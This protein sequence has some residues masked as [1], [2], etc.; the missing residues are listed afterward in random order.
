[1]QMHQML[2]LFVMPGLVTVTSLAQHLMRIHL[3]DG[4]K[5]SLALV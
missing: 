2:F 3:K 1:M 5:V 4:G